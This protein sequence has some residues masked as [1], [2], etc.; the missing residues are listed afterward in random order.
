VSDL[1]R[2]DADLLASDAEREQVVA[3]LRAHLEEGRLTLDE[4]TDRVSSAYAARTRGELA[5]ALRQLPRRQ[6]TEAP[7]EATATRPGHPLERHRVRAARRGSGKTARLPRRLLLVA[8]LAVVLLLLVSV[9]AF[10]FNRSQV[11]HPLP[12]PPP[13]MPHPR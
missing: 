8:A 11:V 1:A 9:T 3:A 6:P 7:A 13:G 10:R 12:A 4:F 5:V 2:G